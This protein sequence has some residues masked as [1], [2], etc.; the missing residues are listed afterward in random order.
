MAPV[1]IVGTFNTTDSTW[2][3]GWDHPSVPEDLGEHARAVRRYGERHHLEPLTTRV[4]SASEEQAWEFAAV[5]DLLG[6]AQCAY[7]GPAG[8]TLVFMTF[9]NPTLSRATDHSQIPEPAAAPARPGPALIGSDVFPRPRAMAPDGIPTAQDS[10][11]LAGPAP[12]FTAEQAI[13]VVQS[14]QRQMEPLYR[15]VAGQRLAATEEDRR[16]AVQEELRAAFWRRPDGFHEG[17]VLGDD[18]SYEIAALTHWHAAPV[19]DRLWQV[20]YRRPLTEDRAMN[21]GYLV[22]LFDDAPQLVDL[23]EDTD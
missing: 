8:E 22:M 13:A 16:F 15:L 21:E 2:M 18:N 9:D 6:R 1:Q 23:I 17:G 3:W 5:A 4:V 7:R 12:A 19:Q 11:H 14:D 10:Q 20:T